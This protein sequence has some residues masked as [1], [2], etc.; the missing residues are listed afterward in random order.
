MYYNIPSVNGSK[1]V[2]AQARLNDLKVWN[3]R[4]VQSGHLKGIKIRTEDKDLV[5]KIKGFLS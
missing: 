3:V 5:E 2:K 4:M 1:V